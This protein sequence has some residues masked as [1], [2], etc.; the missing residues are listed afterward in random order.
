MSRSRTN[1]TISYL[2]AA[3]LT[4]CDADDRP[5]ATPDAGV[6]PLYGLLTMVST[7]T[8]SSTYINLFDTLDFTSV[9]LKQAREFPKYSP[10]DAIG[11]KVF[12]TSG[13]TPTAARFG[14]AGNGAWIEEGAV[15]F[16]NYRSSGGAKNILVSP[17]KALLELDVLGHIVWDPAELRIIGVEPAPPGIPLEREGMNVLRSHD[18]VLRGDRL[19]QAFY[20]SD[21]T[22][23]HYAPISQIAVY[24]TQTNKPTTVL[25]APCPHL[26]IGSQDT[27]GNVY[28]SNGSLSGTSP[29]L[30][31]DQARNCIVRIKAGEEKLDESFTLR[32]ADVTEGR[33]GAGF[34]PLG[35]GRGFFAAFHH[36]RITI[37]PESDSKKVNYSSNWRLWTL[38]LTTRKAAPLEGFDYFAGQYTAFTFEG[39]TFVLLPSADYKTTTTY[40]LAA[41]G[42]AVKR[43]ESTGWTFHMFQVR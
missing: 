29:L 30:F 17:G 5:V 1:I 8:D 36:E 42:T 9:D 33:E 24:D 16:A 11:G 31:K 22:Y 35:T 12:V 32:F 37:R 2:L 25:D 7:D 39:R 40:E 3:V 19:F 27:E 10:A 18:H 13:E 14:I 15:S 38:D 4:G 28:F 21:K 26:H 23:D 6:G 41:D 20:W 34:R 43:F